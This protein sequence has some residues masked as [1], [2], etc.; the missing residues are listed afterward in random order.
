LK[1]KAVRVNVGGFIPRQTA[2]M[3]PAFTSASKTGTP[4]RNGKRRQLGKGVTNNW[5]GLWHSLQTPGERDIHQRGIKTRKK[6]CRES[7]GG[8]GQKIGALVR[9]QIWQQ[10]GKEKSG[11]G[12]GQ[13]HDE[14]GRTISHWAKK[15]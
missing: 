11:V 1:K 8:L 10:K 9:G 6:N 3:K 15:S 13:R 7:L 5:V 12:V 4:P 2:N 14:V